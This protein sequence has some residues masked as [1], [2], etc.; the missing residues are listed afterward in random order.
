MASRWLTGLSDSPVCCGCGS[1]LQPILTP[2]PDK[3]RAVTGKTARGDVMPLTWRGAAE[4]YSS[5]DPFALGDPL[6][7]GAGIYIICKLENSR[8]IK[9]LYIG[10]CDDLRHQLADVKNHRDYSCFIKCGATHVCVISI[11][12]GRQARLYVEADLRAGLYPP[13]N[14]DAFAKWA[15]G[16]DRR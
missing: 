10:E 13:C 11:S 5:S 12:A 3:R 1:A 2:N 16:G 6:P 9:P 4:Q 14:Q 15:T 7:S 8:T